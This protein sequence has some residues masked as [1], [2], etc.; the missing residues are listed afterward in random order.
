M[1]GCGDFIQLLGPDISINILMC[2]EDPSDLVRASTVSSSW[3]NFVIANGFCKQLCLRMFPEISSIAH[4]IE[5]NNTIEPIEVTPYNSAVWA[6]LQRDHKIYAF[7]ARGLTSFLRKDCISEAITASSTDNY[8]EESIQNTLEPSDR[9]EHR[10]LYWSSDGESDPAVAETLFGFPIYSAKAVRFRMGHYKNPTNVEANV[11]DESTPPQGSTDDKIVWTYTSPEFPMAQES[12]LQKFMLPEPVLCIGGILQ[13]ELL[14]RVQRQETDEAEELGMFKLA[15]A[16]YENLWP[17]TIEGG[18]MIFILDCA[19]RPLLPA[20]DVEVLDPSGR[21]ALKY[22][23]KA[24][25]CASP[26]KSDEGETS[27]PSHFRSFS[28]SIRN[29]EQ[30][31]LNRLLGGGAVVVDESD[32]EIL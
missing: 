31:I 5:V 2:L 6:C 26:T 18:R 22:N 32:D 4:T 17:C 11:K 15:D 27:S 3:R 29:W 19:G 1:E 21:C 9:I 20:F 24:G 10:A 14:G 12:C 28:A 30:M 8:P 23:P 25:Y 16:I 13:I 7:L